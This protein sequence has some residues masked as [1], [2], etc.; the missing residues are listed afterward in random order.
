MFCIE[1]LALNVVFVP[2]GLILKAIPWRTSG[3]LLRASSNMLTIITG[4]P[5]NITIQTHAPLFI[6][7][8]AWMPLQPLYIDLAFL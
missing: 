1:S 3:T 7:T 8:H 4:V 5:I 6:L 2:Q